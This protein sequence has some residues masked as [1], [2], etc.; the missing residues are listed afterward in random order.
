MSQREGGDEEQLMWEPP[1]P[2]TFVPHI[3]VWKHVKTG[4]LYHVICVATCSTN[5]ERDMKEKSVL[6][7]SMK[8]GRYFYREL[9]EFLDGRFEPMPKEK[10]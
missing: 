9:S 1:Y 5:G 8:S 4:G 10:E 6:Y 7:F 3:P 2:P